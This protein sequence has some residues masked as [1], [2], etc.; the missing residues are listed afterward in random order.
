MCYTVARALPPIARKRIKKK[1]FRSENSLGVLTNEPAGPQ[2]KFF[3]QA[4]FMTLEDITNHGREGKSIYKER[5]TR[6]NR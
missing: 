3:L 5:E 2:L 4:F 6:E 1:M